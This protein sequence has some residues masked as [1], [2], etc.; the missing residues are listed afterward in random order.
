MGAQMFLE[1]DS[2]LHRVDDSLS[3]YF[4]EELPGSGKSN[5]IIIS[6]YLEK[7]VRTLR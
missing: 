1:T 2:W 7:M 6:D 3:V 5:A 4:L